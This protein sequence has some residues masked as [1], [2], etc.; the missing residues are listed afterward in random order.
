MKRISPLG[1]LLAGALSLGFT[2]PAT[3][4]EN[5]LLEDSSV[6]EGA[7]PNR[8]KGWY[9]F[10]T[11]KEVEGGQFYVTGGT[12]G[13]NTHSGASALQ[14]HFP[15]GADVAQVLWNAH[16]G[17]R[18]IKA[19]PASYTCTFWVKAEDLQE[20]FHTWVAIVGY[21]ADHQRVRELGR[22]VYQTGSTLTAGQW[23]KVSFTFVVPDDKQLATF[24]PSV[25]FKSDPESVAT[26]VPPTTRVLVDDIVITKN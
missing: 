21:Q 23:T 19:E 26:H 24:T 5:G 10:V 17:H 8:P 22:S 11:P 4:Q 2:L 6:E 25:V 3:A 16:P 18:G 20:G 13:E 12:E 14:F 1:L 7:D 9:A 15:E